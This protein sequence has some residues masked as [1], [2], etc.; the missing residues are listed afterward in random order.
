MND[1]VKIALIAAMAVVA[2]TWMALYHSPYQTCV[3]AKS[4]S[5]VADVQ[6]V[7]DEGAANA[8]ASAEA[9]A[10]YGSDASGF[11]TASVPALDYEESASRAKRTA[12]IICAGAQP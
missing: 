8:A 2:V 1:K 9:A 5:I 11:P 3:R 6:Q 4:E 7:H 10:M 12:E